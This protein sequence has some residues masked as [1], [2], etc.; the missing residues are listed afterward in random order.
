MVCGTFDSFLRGHPDFR[1]RRKFCQQ[2]HCINCVG[3]EPS[4]P[5]GVSG[6]AG[7][8]NLQTVLSERKSFECGMSVQFLFRFPSGQIGGQS[9]RQKKIDGGNDCRFGRFS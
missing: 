3:E 8:K 6:K 5:E 7:G 1:Q 4:H 9:G 2:P